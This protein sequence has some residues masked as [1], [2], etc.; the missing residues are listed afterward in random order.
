MGA[1]LSI[2]LFIEEMLL[3]LEANPVLFIF[4]IYRLGL[5]PLG[6]SA[7]AELIWQAKEREKTLLELRGEADFSS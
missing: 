5:F 3:F 4:P 1:A 7:K 2:S 6:T